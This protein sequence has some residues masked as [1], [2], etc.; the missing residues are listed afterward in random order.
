MRL[1]SG[2]CKGIVLQKSIRMFLQA[3]KLRKALPKKNIKK[4]I[5]KAE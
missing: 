5:L 4:K 3:L 2:T 1:E